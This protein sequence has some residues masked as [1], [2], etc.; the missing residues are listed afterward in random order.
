MLKLKLN[1]RT[2]TSQHQLKRELERSMNAAFE[3]SIRRAAPSGVQ[4]RKS[5]NGYIATGPSDSIAK[6]TKR[7]SS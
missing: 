3:A 6:M 5:T 2:I 7:L 4:I 1:G